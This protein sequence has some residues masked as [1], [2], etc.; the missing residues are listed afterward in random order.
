ML[1]GNGGQSVGLEIAV[2]L[3]SEAGQATECG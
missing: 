2:K 1:G 3:L